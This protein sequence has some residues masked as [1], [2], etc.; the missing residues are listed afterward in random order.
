MK[1]FLKSFVYAFAG[2]SYTLKTQLNFKIH[3]FAGFVVIMLGFYFK[4]SVAEWLWVILSIALVLILELLNTAIEVLVD[5]ISPQQNIKAGLIKDVAAAA[6]LI[7][8]I[9]ALVIGLII[10]VPKVI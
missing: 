4:L 8:A 7:A 3:C 9:V 1:K 10:F 2:L 6:V 5:L